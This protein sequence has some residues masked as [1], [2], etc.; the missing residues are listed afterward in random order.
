MHMA[1]SKPIIHVDVKPSNIYL[2]EMFTAKLTNFG[3]SVS[4]SPCEEE[5]LSHAVVETLGYIGPAYEAT[6]RV[7]EKCGVYSFGVVFLESITGRDPITLVTR[8]FKAVDFFAQHLK[9]AGV[10]SKI[11]YPR[12]LREATKEEILAVPDL[13]LRCVARRGEERR[14][15]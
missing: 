2:D 10:V 7:T 11:V 1:L 14:T 13:A 12:E 8:N 5:F 4:I 3:F 15:N 9:Q 6:L